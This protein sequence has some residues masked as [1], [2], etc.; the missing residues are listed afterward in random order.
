MQDEDG[1][2]KK[3]R[4]R[5]SSQQSPNSKQLNKKTRLRDT[6]SKDSNEDI[7]SDSDTDPTVFDTETNM[8]ENKATPVV[9]ISPED[10]LKIAQT[11]KEF[12]IAD[13]NKVIE[14]KQKPIIH[15]ITN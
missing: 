15:E 10:I 8:E 14:E 7:I 3:R 6:S 12:L 4:R 2:D 1:Y 5:Q 9:S 13:L 11:V